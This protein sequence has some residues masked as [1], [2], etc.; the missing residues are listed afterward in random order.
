MMIEKVEGSLAIMLRFSPN[1]NR[2]NL[3]RWHEWGDDV[4]RQAQ[5]EDKPVMLF[6]TAFWCRFCQRMDEGAF[7]DDE[8]IALLNAYFVAIRAEDTQ[9]PDVNTRYNLNGWPTVAF[10]TPKGELLGATNYLPGEEFGNLLA[11]LYTAYHEKKDA[12][13]AA[14]RNSGDA[15]FET[16]ASVTRGPLTESTLSAV[17]AAIMDLADRVHGGYGKGQKFIHPEPNDFLLSRYEATKDATCLDHV[18]LTLDRMKQ[19]EIH[20]HEG[21]GYFRTSSNADWSG[22]HREKLLVEQ[23]GLLAN[24]L[25]AFRITQHRD[26]SL[27]AEEIIDYLN[28]RLSDP[29]D[30]AFYGCEDFLRN[31][32]VEASSAGEFFSIIDSCIYTDANAQAVVAYL[33][34]AEILEASRY[35]EQAL[36][37]LEFLTHRCRN[38]EGGMFHYFDGSAH[39]PGWLSDQARMG[40]ALVHAYRATGAAGYLKQARGLADFILEKFKNPDGGY[41][42]VAALGPA[43]LSFRL[44]LIEQ[45]G[46]AASFFLALA[47]AAKETRYRD[48]ALWALSPFTGDFSSYGIH[49]SAFGQ[50]LVKL[51]HGT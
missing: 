4:F 31:E 48:A 7:S 32:T 17:T 27:M 47:E 23:A 12:I 30:D 51:L 43:Y 3:I 13:R 26:Y 42:D 1:P 29:T 39:V 10:M 50:A 20:D 37:T 34:A 16:P 33:D 11:R 15:P 36:Q 38:P 35:Q 24:S 44:T 28:R 45:N 49:A 2:A 40:I 14:R 6:L 21:G 25:R 41:Y 8:N 19:G 9:R 22:P 5:A 18:C 46:A